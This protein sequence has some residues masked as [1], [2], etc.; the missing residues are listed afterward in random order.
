L[1]TLNNEGPSCD[2]LS[3]GSISSFVF[4]HNSSG[5]YGNQGLAGAAEDVF[6]WW[7]YSCTETTSSSLYISDSSLMSDIVITSNETESFL[8]R[9]SVY[10]PDDQFMSAWRPN[11][12][13][14]NTWQVVYSCTSFTTTYSQSLCVSKATG[15]QEESDSVIDLDRHLVSC[16][17]GK[18]LVGWNGRYNNITGVPRFRFE[19]KCCSLIIANSI[20]SPTLSPTKIEY[21]ETVLYSNS[22]IKNSSL[23]IS[24]VL[25][26]GNLFDLQRYNITCGTLPILGFRYINNI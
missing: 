21:Y 2:N 14:D 20:I 22:A 5:I 10:C 15:F 26:G 25:K 8:E 7:T 23:K 18:G 11:Q 4:S 12:L 6:G 3:E 13:G 24:D 1:N 9:I 16:G 19:Y 17:N